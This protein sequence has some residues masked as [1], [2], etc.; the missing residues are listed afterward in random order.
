[1]GGT[2]TYGEFIPPVGLDPIVSTGHVTTGAVEMGAVYDTILRYNHTTGKYEN[3]TADS[4]TSNADFTVWTL[5]LK[6]GIKFSDGTDYNADAVIFGLN[7]HRSGLPGAPPCQQTISCPSNPTSSTSYMQFVKDLTAIDP[8]TVQITLTEPWS[9]LP[10]MLASEPAMIPSPTALK[11]CDPTQSPRQ[12][13]FNTHPVGAGAFMVQSFTPNESIVMVRNPNY[14][15]GQVYLDGIKFINGGDAGGTKTLDNFKAGV[16]NVALLRT[17]QSIAAAKA[18]NTPGFLSTA[19]AGAALLMNTG[20]TVNCTGGQPAPICAGKPDGPTQTNPPTKDLNVRKAVAAAI[21]PNV[22]DQRAYDGQG[23]PGSELLQKTF[24]WYPNVPGPKYDPAAAKQYVAA[25]KAAGWDGKVRVLFNNSPAG[26]ASGLAVDAMLKAVGIDS[27]LDISKSAGQSTQ[28]YTTLHDF[29]IVGAGLATSNDEGGMV[30]LLQNLSSTSPSNRVG[31]KDPAIDAGLKAIRSA[32]DD[33]GRTAGYKQ[34]AE[35]VNASLPM[36]ALEQVDQYVA[37]APEREGDPGDH[38]R[39]DPVRQGLDQ[40]LALPVR[41][42]V[43][44]VTM[45]HRGAAHDRP[46]STV[47]WRRRTW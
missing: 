12:C 10:F 4:L 11:Q 40:Q 27:Q 39:L 34:V 9:G 35:A 26:Q 1:M 38:A 44:S 28:Q 19:Q 17:P 7:R 23:H 32:P 3:V 13:A 31:I 42:A 22:I 6:P 41:P 33:A 25:A 16:T 2:L 36:M 21:D 43:A 18:A 5:K 47:P 8:L 45:H 46:G 30:A 24:K 37:W 15:G 20:I 14:F 29:D